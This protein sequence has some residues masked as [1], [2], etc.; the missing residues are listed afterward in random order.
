M[1]WVGKTAT[2][3]AVAGAE[4][5]FASD[6]STAE[7][8]ASF[9]VATHAASV[10]STAEQPV[11]AGVAVHV[12]RVGALCARTIDEPESSAYANAKATP[13][14]RIIAKSR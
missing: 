14:R 3:P 4:T 5:H 6:G 8:P 1:N 13:K 11:V 10:G 2:Q 12:A 9:G 7:H